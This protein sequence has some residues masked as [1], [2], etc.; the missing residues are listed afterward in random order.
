MKQ[1]LV[2]LAAM[3]MVIGCSERH[4][5]RQQTQKQV[6]GSLLSFEDFDLETVVALI[7]E[8]KVKGAKELEAFING[9][10]GVNNVDVDKD[11]KIDYIRVVEGRDGQTITLDMVASP[12]G[13]GEEVTVANLR[14]NQST[15]SD[16]MT[17]EGG[18]PTYVSG[19]DSHFYSYHAPR[20]GISVGEAMFLMWLMSPGRGMYVHPVPVYTPRS[21]YSRSAL[22]NRRTAT[23][24]TTKV[25]PVPKTTRPSTYSVK[26]A[27]KTQSKLKAQK[28]STFQKRDSSKTKQN[29]SGFGATKKAAPQKKSGWGSSKPSRSRSWGGGRSSGGRRRSSLRYKTEISQLNSGLEVVENLN[30]VEW[31]WKSENNTIKVK[32][33]TV[34]FIAEDV[35]KLMPELVFKNE[36]GEVE[37][38]NYD[39][40]VVPLV[41]AVKTQQ[42]QIEKLSN[43]LEQLKKNSGTMQGGACQP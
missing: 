26:S 6:Q 39:L 16:Q 27:Q 30:P 15:S 37:G 36:N 7:K 40:I 43:E 17:V 5:D 34:G 42:V 9:D 33:P 24:T 11:G 2:A 4:H 3:V 10:N 19:H 20:S 38:I 29:A 1:F 23:R 14:F 31:H 18:Y 25:S 8:N 41:N 21:V 13:G 35:A 12:S 32:Q 28:A 22:N